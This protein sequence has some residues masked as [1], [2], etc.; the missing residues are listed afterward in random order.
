[1]LVEPDGK[2]RLQ[3]VTVGRDFGDSIDVQAGLSGNELI[4]KQPTASLQQGQVVTPVESQN[5]PQH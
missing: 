1:M 4:V 2:L 5:A 3:N